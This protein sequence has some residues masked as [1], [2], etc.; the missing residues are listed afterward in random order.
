MADILDAIA[1]YLDSRDLVGYDP[2]QAGGGDCFLEREPDAPDAVVTLWLYG[3][4]IPGTAGSDSGLPADGP[5]LRVRVRDGSG[6]RA[7]RAR[8]TVLREVLDGLGPIELYDG[9]LLTL[10][11]ALR[12]APDPM[13]EDES[14]RH[15]HVCDFL[16]HYDESHTPSAP[17]T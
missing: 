17:R 5:R 16:M 10:C 8:C 14:G 15:Q 11:N 4:D 1:R 3:G 13:G 9:V 6:P 2:S 12:A 7:S